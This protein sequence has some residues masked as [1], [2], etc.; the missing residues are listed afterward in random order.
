MQVVA[1]QFVTFVVPFWVRYY[2]TVIFSYH[3]SSVRFNW[4]IL[5]DNLEVHCRGGN[6]I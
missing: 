6:V 2:F 1:C 4:H 3:F 5:G